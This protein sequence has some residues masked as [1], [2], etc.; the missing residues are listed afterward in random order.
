MCPPVKIVPLETP[1][2]VAHMHAERYIAWR[3]QVE[4]WKASAGVRPVLSHVSEETWERHFAA[5]E[6]AFSA[7]AAELEGVDG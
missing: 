2:F 7:V 6:D 4:Q 3:A 5:N 1:L